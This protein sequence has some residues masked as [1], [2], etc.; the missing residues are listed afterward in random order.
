MFTDWL[1]IERLS[2]ELDA[3]AGRSRVTALGHL[4]DG[5]VALECWRKGT[6]R[7]IIFDLFGRVPIITIGS[8]A[9]RLTPEAGFI[10][11]AGA[12]L[13]G[14]TL[15]QVGAIARERIVGF[16]FAARSRFGVEAGYQMLAE[17]IPR[18][19]NLLLLK[20]HTI[21]AAYK[22]FRSAARA[23]R[24]IR[25]G[26]RYEPPPPQQPSPRAV[27]DLTV[28]LQAQDEAAAGRALR[29]VRPQ[30]PQLLANSLLS[31]GEDASQRPEQRAR[32]LLAEADQLLDRA[33]QAAKSEQLFVYREGSRL[34]QA[35]VVPLRQFAALD[36][37]RAAELLPLFNEITGASKSAASEGEPAKR[38]R[39]LAKKL[40]QEQS[41]IQTQISAIDKQL[42][43]V[44]ER[45]ALRKEAEAIFA[46]LYERNP[47]EQA[48][49]KTT[50]ASL[51]ARYK[52]L[53]SSLAPLEKRR[54]ALVQKGKDVDNIA[55]E[56]ERAADDDLADVAQAAQTVL[57]IKP[58][59]GVPK[60][61]A[62]RERIVVTAPGGSRILVGRSPVENAEL[63]FTVARSSDLWFHARN[64]PGAHVI[65]QRDDRREA[66]EN[67]LELAA[68]FAAFF[69]RAKQRQKVD[70]D[71]TSRKHVRKRR[72][73]APGLVS[74]TGAKTIT[75]AP[76]SPEI[77]K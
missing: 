49:A 29:G 65:L 22:E 69:S 20:D 4:D 73:A 19:G 6:T 67:D 54:A 64:T 77:G 24:T 14:L 51:F 56:L 70:V 39:E 9:L 42:E 2:G 28:A 35:H 61:R 53:G 1:L 15:T 46:T 71:Y 58:P 50:A 52:R 47:G 57:G 25:S 48:A 76:R 27:D 43:A 37:S 12:T 60:R 21:V 23:G 68:S 3:A 40:A 63:T 62:K 18:F 11:R 26:A 16:E 10:R 34:V 38:R 7:F 66:P 33:Q 8:G 45:D 13:R 55:W 17:L 74:Y 36:C 32:K 5:R 72:G 44:E 30:L 31:D 41:K 59:P 75:V